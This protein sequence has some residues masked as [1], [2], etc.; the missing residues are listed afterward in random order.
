MFEVG[1]ADGVNVSLPSR[2]LLNDSAQLTEL[3]Y[4]S[5]LVINVD[6]QY[7]WHTRAIIGQAAAR[8]FTTKLGEGRKR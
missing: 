4:P 1:P 5:L 2:H 7:F 3:T 6:E 8:A